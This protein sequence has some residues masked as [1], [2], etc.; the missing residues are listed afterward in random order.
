[1]ELETR[2]DDLHTESVF[3]SDGQGS[4]TGFI[5]PVQEA[6]S[7]FVPPASSQPKPLGLGA[8]GSDEGRE[9]ALVEDH[10]RVTGAPAVLDFACGRRVA[11]Q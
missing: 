10:Q 6:L 11:G 4:S 3:R 8:P 1:M 7:C 9:L 5:V 2:T